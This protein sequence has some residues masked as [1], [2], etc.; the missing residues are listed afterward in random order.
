MIDGLKRLLGNFEGFVKEYPSSPLIDYSEVT[1]DVLQ[2]LY[3]AFLK[4]NAS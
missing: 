1:V 3:R 4:E 2:H